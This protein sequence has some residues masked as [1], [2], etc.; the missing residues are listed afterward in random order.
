MDFS[1]KKI[2]F[3]S[4]RDNNTFINNSVYFHEIYC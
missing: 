3:L 1:P 4:D 2:E